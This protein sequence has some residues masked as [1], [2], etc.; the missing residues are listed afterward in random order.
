M[1]T[2][3][4]A[5]FR[6]LHTEITGN[7][8]NRV[9]SAET[10]REAKDYSS[11]RVVTR[12]LRSRVAEVIESGTPNVTLV[13]QPADARVTTDG[14]QKPEQKPK[15]FKPVTHVTQVVEKNNEAGEKAAN[16]PIIYSC[17]APAPERTRD[18]TPDSRHPLIG[19]EV[20][21]KIEAIE[22]EARAKGWPAELLWNADFWDSPRGLA[23]LLDPE[24]EI[25]EVTPDCIEIVKCRRDIQRFRRHAA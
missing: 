1:K 3:H 20:R 17:G 14:P 6:R 11:S 4:F 19:R 25:V 2:D 8:G 22:A 18:I 5:E 21:A 23:A 15:E 10:P 16:C 13:T 9:T 7:A 24:D 12:D